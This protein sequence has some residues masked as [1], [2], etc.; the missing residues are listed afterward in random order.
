M[1]YVLGTRDL[2]INRHITLNMLETHEAYQHWRDLVFAHSVYYWKKLPVT[3][4]GGG[5][6]LGVNFG[7]EGVGAVNNKKETH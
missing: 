3:V 5:A 6:D 4:V 1:W 2:H 7:F